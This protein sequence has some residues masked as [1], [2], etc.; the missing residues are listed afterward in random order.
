MNYLDVIVLIPVVWGCIR[1]FSKG[2]IIELA[3]LV[4]MIL[5]IMAAYYFSPQ[6]GRFLEEYFT[7]SDSALRVVSYIL[8]FLSVLLVSW[9]IGKIVTKVADLVMLGWLNKLLGAVFGLLK[10]VIIAAILLMVIV[11]FD[12]REKVITRKA[13]EKSMFFQALSKVIPDH[14]LVFGKSQTPAV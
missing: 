11:F 10:G 6:A 2:L 4:G 9:I 3:T 14:I 5:G 12:Q 8:I 7:F 1:G 13:K